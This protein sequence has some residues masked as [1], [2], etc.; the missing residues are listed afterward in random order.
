[1][2]NERTHLPITH[3]KP[4]VHKSRAPGGQVGYILYWTGCH[5]L[6]T[7]SDNLGDYLM[8]QIINQWRTVVQ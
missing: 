8:A 5:S 3:C 6:V 7:D 4:R 2:V 1:V